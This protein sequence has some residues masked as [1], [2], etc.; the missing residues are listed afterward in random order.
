MLLAGVELVGCCVVGVVTVGT[1]D[2]VV[3][4]D[5]VEELDELSIGDATMD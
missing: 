4:V 5:E 3:G 2:D 1:F